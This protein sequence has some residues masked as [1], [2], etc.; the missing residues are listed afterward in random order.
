MLQLK[1]VEVTRAKA[2]D[3]AMSQ[4]IR[5]SLVSFTSRLPSWKHSLF[6][7]DNTLYILS[8]THSK[9]YRAPQNIRFANGEM[10]DLSGTAE[11][12]SRKSTAVYP[13]LDLVSQP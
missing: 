12:A 5:S 10:P 4:P 11:L 8:S 7:P 3:R 13:G 9:W 2:E 1:T 6:F